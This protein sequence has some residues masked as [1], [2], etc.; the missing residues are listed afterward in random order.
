MGHYI[1][2]W[3]DSLQVSKVSTEPRVNEEN[4]DYVCTDTIWFIDLFLAE[5]LCSLR[6]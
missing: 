4:L 6:E 5:V 2:F 1:N 3:K